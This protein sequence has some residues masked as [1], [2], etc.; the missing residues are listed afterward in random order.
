M[1]AAKVLGAGTLLA[2]VAT[3][4]LA[5]PA[6]AARTESAPTRAR[7]TAVGAA[8]KGKVDVDVTVVNKTY[9]FYGESYA[10]MDVRARYRKSGKPVANG[11]VEVSLTL[12]PKGY[13]RDEDG[14]WSLSG[15]GA[16]RVTRTVMVDL[17]GRGRGQ[18]QL[19]QSWRYAEIPPLKGGRSTS[20]GVVY[21]PSG[22]YLGRDVDAGRK[23]VVQRVVKGE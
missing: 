3:S 12:F 21:G 14:D 20:V 16:N 1:R 9:A 22:D 15:T 2:I 8:A 5:G 7:P 17:N 19:G 23:K 18:A 13:R 6:G 4:G 11:K 10:S